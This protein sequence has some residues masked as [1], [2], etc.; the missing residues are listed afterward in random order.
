MRDRCPVAQAGEVFLAPVSW[1]PSSRCTGSA[2][3]CACLTAGLEGPELERPF[4]SPN[5]GCSQLTI[6]ASEETGSCS[7]LGLAFTSP[8]GLPVGS[9]TTVIAYPICKNDVSNLIPQGRGD[10]QPK[11]TLYEGVC[12][13]SWLLH[14]L[15]QC[16]MRNGCA[17][18]ACIPPS[19]CAAY[20][21]L[22]LPV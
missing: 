15:L 17:A 16:V 4:E 20:A 14:R 8:P 3:P 1:R 5:S 7:A 21:L 19:S 22:L 2:S 13:R 12:G 6:P 9:L 18:H 11:V 10:H